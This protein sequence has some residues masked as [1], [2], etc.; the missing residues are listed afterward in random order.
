MVQSVMRLT[1]DPEV[2]GSIPGQATYFVSPSGG[3]QYVHKVLLRRSK[4]AQ[5][6]CG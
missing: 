1:Q 2:P 5:E 3:C 4:P 6:K